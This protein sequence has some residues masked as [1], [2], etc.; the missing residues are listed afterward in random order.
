[1]T[2]NML[3]IIRFLF[4]ILLWSAVAVSE[5]EEDVP[6]FNMNSFGQGKA[7]PN[8][9]CSSGMTPVPKSRGL[10]FTSTGCSSMGSGMVMNMGA[11]SS[12]EEPSTEVYASCCD[13]WHACYQ[14]CGVSKKACDDS[15]KTCST[16]KCGADAECTKQIELN[17]MLMN[18]GGCQK[19]DQAQYQACD[20]VDKKKAPAQREAAIKR[21]YKKFAPGNED[22]AAE[23]VKKADTASKLAAL[24]RKLIGKYPNAIQKIE[25]PQQAM[26][27]K[28]MQDAKQGDEEKV[29]EEILDDDGDEQDDDV[30]E[31]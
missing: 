29:T 24:L 23:L 11:A 3:H 15:F 21:F 26:Y 19:F 18:L 13:E 20:C 28:M 25:D 6:P 2:G 14:I 4:W 17:T 10:K 31:L 22:K 16:A 27:R 9:R 1:M 7:C 8:Y 12:E 5:Q 30:Q